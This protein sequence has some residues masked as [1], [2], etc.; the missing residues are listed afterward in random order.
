MSVSVKA[1]LRFAFSLSG[2][3]ES[4]CPGNLFCRAG[5]LL[6]REQRLGAGTVAAPRPR[7]NFD[8]V[9]WVE[10]LMVTRNLLRRTS[11]IDVQNRVGTAEHGFQFDA[12]GIAELA[13]G[14]ING[15][16]EHRLDNLRLGEMLVQPVPQI[17]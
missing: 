2:W 6:C 14:D 11:V 9:H 4:G 1:V 10:L 15:D 12:Q 13:D 7:E 16:R 8:L 3:V 17:L 5:E